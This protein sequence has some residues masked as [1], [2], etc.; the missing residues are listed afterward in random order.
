MNP[1]EAGVDAGALEQ[2]RSAAEAALP[3][4]PVAAGAVAEAVPAAEVP[5]DWPAVLQRFTGTPSGWCALVLDPATVGD[6]VS[7]IARARD[8]AAG[9]DAGTDTG[10]DT[11]GDLA[12]ACDPALRAATGALGPVAG[13][14]PEATTAAALPTGTDAAVVR[15]AVDGAPAAYLLLSVAAGSGVPAPRRPA[16]AGA[17]PGPGPGASAAATAHG[18]ELLRSVPMEVTA[19]IGR[20]RMTIQELLALTPGAVVELDRPVGSPA[21]VLVN[22]RL[23]ARGEVVV[24]DE[25]FAIRITEIVDATETPGT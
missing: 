25:D 21:D 20:T 17:V 18:L 5:G 24:V 15:I 1:A 6:L 10:T 4:L 22:G 19:E 12:A 2:A 11:D 23:F 3:L 7:A 9:A 13:L 14:D 8:D 16:D